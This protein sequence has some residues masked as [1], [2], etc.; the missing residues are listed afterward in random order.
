MDPDQLL[1]SGERGFHLLFDTPIIAAAFEQDAHALRHVVGARGREFQQA[2]AKLLGQPSAER[3]RRFIAA[4][5]REFQYLI[6]LLYF[7]LLDSRVRASSSL[8]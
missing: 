6:V 1:S 5:P 8:H 2:L 4:L 3:G 7:D